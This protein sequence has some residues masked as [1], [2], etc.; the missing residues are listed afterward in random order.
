MSK[1]EWLYWLG[2][3]KSVR[4]SSINDAENWQDLIFV[5][6]RFGNFIS[7]AGNG[8]GGYERAI[9]CSLSGVDLGLYKA[10]RVARNDAVHQ[11]FQARHLAKNAVRLVHNFEQEIMGKLIE[12]SGGVKAEY[13]MTGSPFVAHGWHGLEM[14][15]NVMATNGYSRV[16]LFQD[17]N[18]KWVTDE[19][20]AT[21]WYC[22]KDRNNSLL[23]CIVKN[24]CGLI[25]C[26]VVAKDE[27]VD[28]PGFYLV[29]NDATG[30]NVVGIITPFDFL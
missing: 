3:F 21:F 12:M 26:D 22:K 1:E 9:A 15:R 30:N 8:L 17:G 25:G 27:V 20:V 4:C 5:I 24:K 18:Y 7:P 14:I 23:S 6:E 29:V 11:G 13:L 16:P 10:V 19:Q 28:K 2:S